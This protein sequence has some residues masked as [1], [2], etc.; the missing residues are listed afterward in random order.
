MA[1]EIQAE[2]VCPD[3]PRQ[4][5]APAHAAV[6]DTRHR[7]AEIAGAT[8]A[9]P[10]EVQD[11]LKDCPAILLAAL[12]VADASRD[13][14]YEPFKGRTPYFSRLLEAT[15]RVCAKD[16]NLAFAVFNYV[17]LFWCQPW[18]KEVMGIA[19]ESNPEAFFDKVDSLSRLP[20]YSKILEIVARALA[21]R[22][23]GA[24]IDEVENS[25]FDNQ[26]WAPAVMA[27]AKR[28]LAE[29]ADIQ[30]KGMR[31]GYEQ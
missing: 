23:P 8:A 15:A 18:V 17:K 6:H 7:V 20:F 3:A 25:F 11:L 30:E 4:G 5:A 22:Y 1:E 21:Q 19:A 12:S 24:L 26:P 2:V 13:P 16:R 10:P 28:N 9:F 27:I 31:L 29:G 14:F